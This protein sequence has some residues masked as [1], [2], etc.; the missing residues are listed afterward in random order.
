[1][2]LLNLVFFGGMLILGGCVSQH[3]GATTASADTEEIYVPLGS[4]IAKKGKPAQD[5]ANDLQQLQN[6]RLNSGTA[7][8]GK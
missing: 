1:M 2:K 4:A 7:N 5:Q 6:A 8:T 3:E